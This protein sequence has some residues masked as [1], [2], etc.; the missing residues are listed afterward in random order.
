MSDLNAQFRRSARD[1][2][3]RLEALLTSV[4]QH[5][6]DEEVHRALHREIH[7]LKGEANMLGLETTRRVAE[8]VEE[9]IHR[10]GDA[11]DLDS[12]ALQ[13]VFEG[14]EH[15]ADLIGGLDGLG[16]EG[17]WRDD[18]YEARVVALTAAT[19]ASQEERSPRAAEAPPRLGADVLPAVEAEGA[20][21]DLDVRLPV[22]RI[23]ALL[24]LVSSIEISQKERLASG[25][26]LLPLRETLGGLRRSILAMATP[27]HAAAKHAEVDTDATRAA[28]AACD[29]LDRGLRNAIQSARNAATEDTGHLD[30]LSASVRD[31]ATVRVADAFAGYPRL[32]RRVA[33]E[34]GKDVVLRMECDPLKVERRVME[35]LSEPLVHLLTNAIDHGVESA[36][37]RAARGKPKTATVT[38]SA[39][40]AGARMHITVQDDGAGI[41]IEALRRRAVADGLMDEEAA[42]TLSEGDALQLLTGAGFTTRTEVTRLSGRGVGLDVVRARVDALGGHLS[43]RSIPGRGATFELDVPT[44]ATLAH[45]VVVEAS[46]SAFALPMYAVAAILDAATLRIERAGRGKVVRIDGAPILLRRLSDALGLEGN[47]TAEVSRV[48]VVAHGT[49]RRAFLVDAI[50][51]TQVVVVHPVGKFLAASSLIRSLATSADGRVAPMLDPQ[52]LFAEVASSRREPTSDR[53]T[54]ASILVVDDSEIARQIVVDVLVKAGFSVAQA[55]DGRAAMIELARAMPDAIVTDL[56][57]P[58]MD[59][60]QLLRA[61]RAAPSF[62][63][64]PII[65][66]SS[67]AAE[68]DKQRAGALGADAYIVKEALDGPTLCDTVTRLVGA[69]AP[70]DPVDRGAPA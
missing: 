40:L 60:F 14:L 19:T 55:M 39:R 38:L 59:G 12:A 62:S 22:E 69:K 57:M 20:S 43:L 35:S 25:G 21:V 26:D 11:Q 13:L 54:S 6:A 23:E 16:N 67:L 51:G 17:A 9:A 2:L 48:I 36:S 24:R 32:F 3:D 8:L 44:S 46:G 64:L 30:A 5:T 49:S 58:I 29:D 31:I 47:R 33:R 34:A 4:E 53:A 41:A 52:G 65:V 27:T 1:R 37:E 18:D 70:S 45:A 10:L 68:A 66:L 42:E 50:L 63:H 28:L 56:E 61:I 7:T 15:L